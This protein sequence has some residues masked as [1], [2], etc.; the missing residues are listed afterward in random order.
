VASEFLR[1]F[2]SQYSDASSCLPEASSGARHGPVAECSSAVNRLCRLV[3]DSLSDPILAGH[4]SSSTVTPRVRASVERWVYARVGPML[5]RLYESQSREEDRLFVE[6]LQA[7]ANVSDAALLDALEVRSAFRGAAAIKAPAGSLGKLKQGDKA[8]SV[9][10]YAPSQKTCSTAAG[11]E[12]SSSSPCTGGESKAAVQRQEACAESVADGSLGDSELAA[13]SYDRV[14]SG[15]LQVE[16]M[17][18]Q[19]HSSPREAVET[20]VSLQREM[21]ECA[22]ES[23]GEHLS[24]MD[25]IMPIFI[26]VLA[27]SFCNS[28]SACARLMS[29]ALTH[30][31]QMGKE[32]RA[33]LL[34]E[35]AARYVASHWDIEPLVTSHQGGR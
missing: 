2:S 15:L 3:N 14:A 22:Y 5:W 34:L 33:V 24:A 10:E 28:P 19:M 30:D 17:L 7:L 12:A 23:S 20:L 4:A 6:K 29:Q 26:F 18:S 31:E 21:K 27:R 1:N 9:S 32:G 16:A 11:T 25:D 13:A 8:D 35:C